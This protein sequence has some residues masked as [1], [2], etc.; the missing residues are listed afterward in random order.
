MIEFIY[1]NVINVFTNMTLFERNQN[2][3][4]RMFFENNQNKKVKLMFA[5]DKVKH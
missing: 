3:H 5:K 2:Y 4:S 1:N